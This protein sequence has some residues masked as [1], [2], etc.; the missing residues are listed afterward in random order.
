M[1]L[2]IVLIGIGVVGMTAVIFY[3]LRKKNF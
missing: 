2:Y 3:V 1:A